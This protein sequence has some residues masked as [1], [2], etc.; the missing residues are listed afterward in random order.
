MKTRIFICPHLFVR[1]KS[2]FYE[3]FRTFSLACLLATEKN[4]SCCCIWVESCEF[5][6]KSG[7]LCEATQLQ[8]NTF[9][10]GKSQDLAGLG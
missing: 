1:Q 5:S 8:T 2:G 9:L 10:D 4:S 3:I 6:E 7:Q